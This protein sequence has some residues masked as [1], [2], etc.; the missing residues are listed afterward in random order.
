MDG[1]VVRAPFFLVQEVQV[2]IHL[3]GVLGLERSDFQIERHQGLEKAVVEE[4]IDEVLLA[5]RGP[6]GVGG[7]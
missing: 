3:A 4:Q 2:E 7:R 6:S 1:L 5:A